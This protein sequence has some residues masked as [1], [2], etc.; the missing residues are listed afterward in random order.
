MQTRDV[1]RCFVFGENKNPV[2]VCT[3]MAGETTP[4]G[5]EQVSTS[6]V[7]TVDM[8]LRLLLLLLL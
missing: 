3:T 8:N 4:D 2:S 1:D 6:K 7:D 5:S